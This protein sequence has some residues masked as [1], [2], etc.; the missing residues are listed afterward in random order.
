[1]NEMSLSALYRRLTASAP[2]SLDA[3]A[4]AGAADGT[5]DA[6]ARDHVA[7]S[8]ASSATEAKLVQM[9]A[10]LR[11]DSETLAGNVARTRRDTAHRRDA[12]TDRRVAAA[13][14]R[15]HGAMRWATALAACL[16]AVVGVFTLHRDHL[17]PQA[18]VQQR[19]VADEIFSTRDTIFR[20][21]ME[22]PHSQ[23]SSRRDDH[24]FHGDF[25]S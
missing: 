9:L 13:P 4:I 16:V 10:A 1:M 22:A 14:Q 17:A 8:V 25:G 6:T 12:R 15:R 11:T 3:E 19:A 24:L 5:L 18:V 20:V 23:T 7:A 21:G 2:T